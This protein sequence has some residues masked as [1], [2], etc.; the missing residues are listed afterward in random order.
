[1]NNYDF[2][3]PR[4]IKVY[5]DLSSVLCEETRLNIVKDYFNING[6][7]KHQIDTFNWF[8]VKGLK[9]IINNEPSIKYE[10]SKY[11]S[12]TLKFSNICV[13]PPT[14]IDDDRIIRN[15]YPQE[16]RNKDLSYTGNVCVDMK[17][18]KEDRPK[19]TNNTEFP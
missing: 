3:Q 8:V 11:D 12:Y 10:S 13:E 9:N 17:T 18:M 2:K 15:L 19:S 1:M 5:Q 14:I 7:V 16:A 4:S 6:L